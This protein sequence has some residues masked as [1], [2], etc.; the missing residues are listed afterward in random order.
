MKKMICLFAA[1]AMMVAAS[2][3]SNPASSKNVESSANEVK[4]EV[5]HAMLAVNGSCGMCKTRIEKTAKDIEGVSTAEWNQ[6]KQEIH[7][8]FDASKTSLKNI[9]EALAQ[10]GH[11]TGLDNAP[12]EIYEALPGCCHYRK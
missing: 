8:H 11:D 10:V 1:V 6:E 3:C 5:T 4:S 9:S 12:D 7:L 2:A